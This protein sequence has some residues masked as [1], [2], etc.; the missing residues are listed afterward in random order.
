VGRA[1]LGGVEE[2][3]EGI[4]SLS[5]RYKRSQVV[6]ADKACSWGL[7]DAK[8]HPLP[9]DPQNITLIVA[10]DG[11]SATIEALKGSWKGGG[12]IL[13][14]TP[15]DSPPYCGG[16]PDDAAVFVKIDTTWWQWVII[17]CLFGFLWY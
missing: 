7:Y 4:Y 11:K 16:S 8:S 2:R 5:L 13:I 10:P 1:Q 3:S 14:A 9:R 17:F 15:A 12:A 6:T